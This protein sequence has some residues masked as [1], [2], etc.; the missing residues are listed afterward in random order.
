M[1]KGQYDQA[2]TEAERGIALNPNF[3]LG[4]LRLADVMNNLARPTE[5]LVAVE[6]AMRLDPLNRDNYLFEQGFAYTNLGRYE[7]AIPAV[8]RDLAL[9]NNPWDHVWLVLDYIELG[10]EDAARA[11][12]A[13]VERRVALN[14]DSPM[15]YLALA[16]VMNHMAEPAQALVAVGKAMRLDLGNRDRYLSEEGWAYRGLGRYEDS[17]SAYKGFL[18]LHH[19]IFWAHLALAVDDIE[20][21]HDDDARAE[22]AEALRLNPQFSVDAVFR[23]VGP[24]GQVLA[25]QKR[26]S[27]DLRKAGLK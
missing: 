21:G 13:E 15:G 18:A 20:L 17:I 10:Q 19:D 6:K 22:A 1:Q 11:E 3:P 25:E 16:I 24:K 2:V 27:A 9:T 26:W 12:A 4:Y 23:T 14:P 8:K 5:A 7:E